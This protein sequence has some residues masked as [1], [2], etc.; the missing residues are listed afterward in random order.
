MSH[1]EKKSKIKNLKINEE[2]HLLLKNHC[3]KHGLK[4]FYFV[5]KLIKDNCKPEKGI[6][7][8]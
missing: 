3:K 1:K 4:M 7:F 2:T 5:E 8:E 6:Y